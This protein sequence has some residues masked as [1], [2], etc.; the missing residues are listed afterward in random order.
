MIWD[1]WHHKCNI[2]VLTFIN[3]TKQDLF[4][5]ILDYTFSIIRKWNNYIFTDFTHKPSLTN[6]PEEFWP[7]RSPSHT[8]CRFCACSRG[9]RW[10][11][12][13][14]CETKAEQ[15]VWTFLGFVCT[16][17]AEG[18]CGKY[19]AITYQ[20]TNVLTWFATTASCGSSGSAAARRACS[21]NKTVRRVIAAALS[22][23][24][25]DVMPTALIKLLM[26]SDDSHSPLVFQNV[27]TYCSCH[28]TYIRMPDFCDKTHL[29][30]KK[31]SCGVWIKGRKQHLWC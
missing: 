12:L 28:R 11:R 2:N 31:W 16:G 7:Y 4:T 9:S 3:S 19:S 5:H 23:T 8:I 20:S 21:D 13:H 17:Q 22:D 15:S 6:S 10:G 1:K 14:R 24:G 30:K 25:P 29:R 27:Q 26:R 18:E